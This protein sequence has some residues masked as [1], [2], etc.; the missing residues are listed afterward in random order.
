M[1]LIK[2]FPAFLLLSLAVLFGGASALSSCGKEAEKDTSQQIDVFSSLQDVG[3]LDLA[4]MVV[5]K[6]G[7]ITDP[8]FRKAEGLMA[9]TE[10]LVDKMKVGQR[11]GVYSYDTYILASI[12]LTQL[13]PEDVV[14]DE[15]NR[16]VT[17]TLPPVTVTME[18][19]DIQLKEEHYRVNGLRSDISPSER[20]R[21]KEQMNA[22]VKKEVNADNTLRDRLK[23]SAERRAVSYFTSLLSDMGYE[24]HVAVRH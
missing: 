15:E 9:K 4:R 13:R 21:L 24:A 2:K 5:G 16:S 18:G 22:E 17:M 3:R 7:A 10:A 19:R 6:V 14:V 8:S 12:D 1:R 11:I 20:A 23:A